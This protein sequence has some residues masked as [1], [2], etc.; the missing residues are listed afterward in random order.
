MRFVKS[1]LLGAAGAFGLNAVVAG[2]LVPPA[3]FGLAPWL[4]SDLALSLT[5]LPVQLW[6]ALSAVA[7]TLLVMRAMG[8]FETE[9]RQLLARLTAERERDQQAA[10]HAQLAARRAA[11]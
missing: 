1:L 5:G 8:V 2:L 3:P 6:R 9:R 4:N 11:E 10:L 7:V